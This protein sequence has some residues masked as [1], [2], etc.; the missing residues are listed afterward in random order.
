MGGPR[1]AFVIPALNEERS[2]ARVVESLRGVGTPIV[3][4]DG[5]RDRTAQLARNAGADVVSHRANRGYDNALNTGFERAA[6][7]GFDYIITFDADG[8]HDPSLV[9]RFV[10]ELDAGASVVA[11]VRDRKQRLGEHVFAWVAGL[12]WGIAD[13]LCG[14]KGYRRDLYESLGH[15]DSYRS[16]GTELAI[17][18]ARTKRKIAQVPVRTFDRADQPRFGRRLN[19]NWRILRAAW[20]ALVPPRRPA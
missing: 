15:F 18:A 10:Q 19:A 13:P 6:Q 3:V 11:G 7:A 4:D 12:A 16:I 17:H 9:Q 1:V 2:I 8:Q 5:S 20:L 14:M